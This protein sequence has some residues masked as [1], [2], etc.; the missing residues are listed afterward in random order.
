MKAIHNDEET[1]RK[2]HIVGNYK[3][4]YNFESNSQRMDPDE[5][6][7]RVGNYKL[8][9]NFESNSQL[10]FFTVNWLVSW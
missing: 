8:K 4:K 5:A 2:L 10:V 1:I 7:M 9:Y 3:L 6:G